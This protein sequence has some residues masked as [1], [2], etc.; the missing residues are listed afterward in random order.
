MTIVDKES[1]LGFTTNKRL[2]VLRDG[3]L[4]YYSKVPKELNKF[5]APNIKTLKMNDWPKSAIDST[6]IHQVRSD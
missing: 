4:Y 2:L 3:C 1:K 6:Y 5:E